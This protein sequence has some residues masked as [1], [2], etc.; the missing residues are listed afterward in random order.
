MTSINIGHGFEH[1]VQLVHW[2]NELIN[3]NLGHDYNHLFCSNIPK[4]QCLTFGQTYNMELIS[5]PWTQKITTLILGDAFNQS[6]NALSWPELIKIT[7]GMRFNKT[8]N[9]IYWPKLESLKM[10][11]RYNQPFNDINWP[12]LRSIDLGMSFNQPTYQAHWPNLESMTSW[13]DF[14]PDIYRIK[15]PAS[16]H[17][18]TLGV[19]INLAI[20]LPDTLRELIFTDDFNQDISDLKLPKSLCTLAL[21][22]EFNY[23]I[24]KVFF[25]R[26]LK[27]IKFSA[28]FDQDISHVVFHEIEYI[29]DYSCKITINSCKFP[30]TLYKIIYGIDYEYQCTV[31]T[32]NTGKHTKCA[33]HI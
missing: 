33:V 7:F 29:Y 1:D 22:D 27:I 20:Q 17:T 15:W 14:T 23:D 6:I 24:S 3:L 21:G 16:L 32:R 11:R 25:P 4:L 31:Y 2:P 10:G 13:H 18:M 8:L 30:E 19:I 9:D 12:S 26:S 28:N 5:A